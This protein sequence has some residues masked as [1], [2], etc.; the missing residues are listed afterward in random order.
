MTYS[1]EVMKLSKRYR[2]GRGLTNLRELFSRR[3]GTENERYHW[4]V[5]DVSFAVQ[6]GEALGIIGPNGAGKTTILKMLS[7]VTKPT[8]GTVSVRGRFSA[9]I[10]LGAGFHPDLTGRENIYLNGAILG[11]KREEI[12]QRF[13]EIVAF[14]GIG[15]YLDT[16]VKRYSSGMYARLGFAIAAHV[17]PDV[18][19]VDEVLAVGDYAFQMKCHARMD[20]L[21]SR[22]TSLIFVSH[23]FEAV[24][25]VC[26]R[27][28]VM[29]QGKNSFQGTAA[30]S[31]VAYSNA[32]RDAARQSRPG[33]I[34]EN[35]L[36]QRVMT[37]GAEIERIQ[38]LDE[39]ERPV[40]SLPSGATATI[41]LDFCFREPA[42][43]PVFAISIRTKDGRL[44][45]NTTTRW[46]GYKTG[47]FAAGERGC[48]T[49]RIHLGLLAGEYD[50]GGDIADSKLT[51]YFDCHERAC[52]FLVTGTNEAQGIAD[53]QAEFGISLT[54]TVSVDHEYANR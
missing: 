22:G 47:Y 38:V 4:A 5:Q 36:S 32:I 44:V 37:F 1:I 42:L 24:R 48:V 30:D 8:G 3:G 7:Q 34:G 10:E 9:L 54:A 51:H 53:L 11:M 40:N 28:L 45:Y 23:N 26:D 27:G 33:A 20:E 52:S 39:N 41:A 16:P 29:Y 35:G 25:R 50:V 19:L 6:P 18:L 49:F 13:D 46:L 12:R 15:D 17:D 14:A 21:R 2:K 31:I 43:E